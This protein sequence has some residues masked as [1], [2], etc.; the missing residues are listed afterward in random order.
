MLKAPWKQGLTCVLASPHFTELTDHKHA[1]VAWSAVGLCAARGWKSSVM[2]CRAAGAQREGGSGRRGN[3]ENGGY[4]QRGRG[5][6][7]NEE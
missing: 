7:K 5:T 4:K 3:R 1:R 6:G 2:V